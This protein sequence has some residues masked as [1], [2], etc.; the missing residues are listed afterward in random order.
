M[1]TA[2]EL[3]EVRVQS[4]YEA[5]ERLRP[6]WF[7]VRPPRYVTDPTPVVP[8]AF[9]DNNMLGDLDQLW[10]IVV[11]DAR[12]IRYLDPRKATMRFGMEYNSGII[13]VITR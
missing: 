11:S 9:L 3:A 2:A 13:Q 10:T 1:I 8:V 12:E 4:V 7:T 6:Q 5:V